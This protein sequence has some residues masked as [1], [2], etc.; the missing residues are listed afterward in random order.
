M[1]A[2]AGRGGSKAEPSP[3]PVF[4]HPR[5]EAN[6]ACRVAADASARR[7]AG[8]VEGIRGRE[9][10]AQ[11]TAL[12]DAHGSG[13]GGACRCQPHFRSSAA[14]GGGS[15]ATLRD[16]GP[17]MDT[18]HA[19]SRCRASCVCL[20]G[21]PLR[22]DASAVRV[23]ESEKNARADLPAHPAPRE[24]AH[25]PARWATRLGVLRERLQ[26]ADRHHVRRP[27]PESTARLSRVGP[28]P[29]TTPVGRAG[30]LSR[31]R[32]GSRW[33]LLASAPARTASPACSRPMTSDHSRIFGC[34]KQRGTPPRKSHTTV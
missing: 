6:Q 23:R 22:R 5:Y 32:P 27:L 31:G 1:D 20:E 25:A 28:L 10:A 29:G 4:S 3:S 15:D 11:G 2:S 24:S 17:A 16:P 18:A 13:T 30:V 7:Q 34:G 12:M 21:P 33:P 19:S 8:T 26:S 14:T 9:S